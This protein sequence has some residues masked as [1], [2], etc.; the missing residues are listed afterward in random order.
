VHPLLLALHGGE[1]GAEL[2]RGQEERV[3]A[4]AELS[5][6]P[7]LRVPLIGLGGHRVGSDAFLVRDCG[8][9]DLMELLL[10]LGET[11]DRGEETRGELGA[12][13]GLALL[14]LP[15]LPLLTLGADVEAEPA[16]ALLGLR[17]RPGLWDGGLEEVRAT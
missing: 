7:G 12:L 9:L 11:G 6:G 3:L 15:G 2:L 5:G 1:E 13:T 16:R 14:V 17:V 4:G 10:V 8:D